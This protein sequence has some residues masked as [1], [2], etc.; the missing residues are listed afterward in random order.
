MKKV[1]GWLLD[2][3]ALLW[4]LYGDKRLSAAA[5]KAIDGDRLLYVSVASFW[6]IAIKQGSKR[7]DFEIDPS[8]DELF[9]NELKRIRVVELSTLP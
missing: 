9:Q 6:E 5:A 8:W 1:K 3:H 2:T 7:F 4:M